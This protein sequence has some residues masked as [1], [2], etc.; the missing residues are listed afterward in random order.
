VRESERAESRECRE[1]REYRNRGGGSTSGAKH[2]GGCRDGRLASGLQVALPAP[3][4]LLAY[5]V[6]ARAG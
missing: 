1:Y 5:G 6:A 2:T 4:R 3:D